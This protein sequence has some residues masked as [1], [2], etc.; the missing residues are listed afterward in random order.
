MIARMPIP[1]PRTE[2]EQK[3][4][5][6]ALGDVDELIGG[7]ERLIA[8]KRDIKQAAVQQLL[9]GQTRLPGFT[10]KWE[11]TTLGQVGECIIGLT[12]KP[13]NTAEYGL[14]VLRASNIQEGRLTYNDNV[15]VN[16]D[17]S[18]KLLTRSGDILICVRNGSR[19]LIGKCARIGEDAM[20]LTFGAFMAIYRTKH[21]QFVFHAF[22]AND[23]QRQIQENVGATIN[24]ITNK[25]LKSFRVRL[26]PEDEQEA[27]VT[28]LS[29]MDAEIEALEKRLA[30]TRALKQGMMQELLTGKTRLV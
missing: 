22:Q 4:I 5:T 11:E 1:F 14:L 2:A 18:Q 23:I 17:V 20:G 16:I 3:A 7:L 15:Y 29:Y 8:K 28:V 6:G 25:D 27:I 12:Y 30:K 10:G 13:E 9:T 26:P 19:A 24:Q 21:S